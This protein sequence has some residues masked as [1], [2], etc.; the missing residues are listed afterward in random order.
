MQGQLQLTA[1]LACRYLAGDALQRLGMAGRNSTQVA[2]DILRAYL[3][4]IEMLGTHFAR[5]AASGLR[6]AVHASLISRIATS[7]PMHAAPCPSLASR[8]SAPP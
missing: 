1:Y 2:V 8:S 4:E 3:E 5:L 7:G 6:C